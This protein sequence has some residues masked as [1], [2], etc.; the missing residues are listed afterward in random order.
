MARRIDLDAVDAR[1]QR[2][3]RCVMAVG[4][5][6]LLD[7]YPVL[8][9]EPRLHG[10]DALPEG[11]GSVVFAIMADRHLREPCLQRKR[12]QA[13]SGHIT[14]PVEVSANAERRS[15]FRRHCPT[16]SE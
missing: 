10:D 2:A 16:L 3:R 12:R 14:A 11:A 8:A 4:A 5:G 13:S 9:S 7:R 1:A 6:E 15:H